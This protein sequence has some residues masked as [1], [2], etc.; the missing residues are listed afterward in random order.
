MALPEVKYNELAP[1]VMASK[2][3]NGCIAIATEGRVTPNQS[4][5][6]PK[7]DVTIKEAEVN[8]PIGIFGYYKSL[9][10]EFSQNLTNS[11]K[12]YGQDL[13]S[14]KVIDITG[15]VILNNNKIT[16][17]GSLI[18]EIGTM[19][20]DKEDVSVPGMVIKIISNGNS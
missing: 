17:S 3:P 4:W 9:T 10:L 11:V 20:G 19:A 6:H 2:F 16:L 12:I 15:K 14:K 5:I 8:K 13:L 18:E 7:A 1:Y